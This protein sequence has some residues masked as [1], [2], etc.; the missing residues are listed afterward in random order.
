MEWKPAA[1]HHPNIQGGNGDWNEAPGAPCLQCTM[2]LLHMLSGVGGVPGE[3][4]PERGC[5]LPGGRHRARPQPH[6][7]LPGPH[8]PTHL[9]QVNPHIY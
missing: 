9:P 5:P 6:M 7:P 3:A 2:P 4:A 1:G 8:L